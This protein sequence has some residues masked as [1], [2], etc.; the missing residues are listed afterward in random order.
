MIYP[1]PTNYR[2]GTLNF[3]SFA[4]FSIA[5]FVGVKKAFLFLFGE[6]GVIHAQQRL[7]MGGGIAQR[8]AGRS[9][10]S[11]CIGSPQH[12]HETICAGF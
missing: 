4:R 8:H 7:V 12:E 10:S 6:A 2:F 9:R 11:F 5:L 1:K 3:A